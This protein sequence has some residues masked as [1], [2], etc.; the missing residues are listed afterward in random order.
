MGEF[1]LG[2]SSL[3]TIGMFFLLLLLGMYELPSGCL[4]AGFA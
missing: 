1:L 2:F 4:V 3:V